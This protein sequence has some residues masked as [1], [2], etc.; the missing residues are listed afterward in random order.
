MAR[1]AEKVESL[2]REDGELVDALEVVLDVA[3][4]EGTVAWSDVS[5]EM[6]SGQ[7]G[8]L[9]EKG[10]LVDADGAGFVLEDPDGVRDALTDDDVDAAAS[11]GE[12]ES[13]W[14]TKDKAAAGL[15]LGMMAGYAVPTVRD[16]I[17]GTL[18]V[19]FGPLAATVP[20][21]VVVMI[22]AIFTGIF[23]T[24]A[25]SNLMNMD[26]MSAQQ[27]RMKDIQERR[28]AAKERGDDE[29]L[30]RIQ[31]EQM[32]AMGDQLGAFKD[33][34]RPMVWI[35]LMTIPIFLWMYWMLQTG[36][37]IVPDQITLPLLGE[38][39]WNDG[40][41]PMPVWIVWYFI[42]SLGFTQ[43]IRKALH[44]QTTPT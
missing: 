17:G 26:K 32:E 13:T 33:Q 9:I 8:R 2:A 29:A 7:W 19:L 5:D 10:I 31:K 15:A 35:M 25:Q 28:K 40:A 36:Q 42:C 37:P 20:F 22:L 27:E 38:A 3:E 11:E 23:S 41:G 4:T 14:T 18:D 6:T 30:D 16:T 21:Y 34:M 24:I 1:T 44:V 12:E 43:I 39:G